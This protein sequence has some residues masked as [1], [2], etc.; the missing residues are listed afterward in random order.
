VAAPVDWEQGRAQACAVSGSRCHL[1][2]IRVRGRRDK[3]N[4]SHARRSHQKTRERH[5]SPLHYSFSLPPP[6]PSTRTVTYRSPPWFA[7]ANTLPFR[8]ASALAVPTCS[9]LAALA[10][11]RDEKGGATP[12]PSTRTMVLCTGT[13]GSL[14]RCAPRHGRPGRAA[15]AAGRRTRSLPDSLPG[16]RP[17]FI[18]GALARIFR[19]K[20]IKALVD[21][22]AAGHA[23]VGTAEGE[24]EQESGAG[25]TAVGYAG[26][27]PRE[28]EREVRGRGGA[29][30]A[31]FPTQFLRECICHTSCMNSIGTQ[32][33]PLEL[34]A[35]PLA[36]AKFHDRFAPPPA[37]LHHVCMWRQSSRC[38]CGRGRGLMASR[39]IVRGERVFCEH[40]FVYAPRGDKFSQ[41]LYVPTI[42][43]AFT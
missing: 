41:V 6:P 33:Q 26:G 11:N 36:A 8:A 2:R 29:R 30:A 1:E 35:W 18:K 9:G 38:P 20:N 5:R 10:Q 13:R 27:A 15:R 23:P 14:V 21:H 16:S 17:D 34:D 39:D 24:M 4:S 3:P 22:N 19:P 28:V 12:R 7:A 42:L 40:V 37:A 31:L 43:R 25:N 32:A